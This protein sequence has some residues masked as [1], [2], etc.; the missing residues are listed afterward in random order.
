MLSDVDE[1][2]DIKSEK[3]D[4]KAFEYASRNF[5]VY[6]ER[7]KEVMRDVVGYGY[8]LYTRA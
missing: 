4:V 6:G 7:M 2:P 3:L 1:I 8:D 5:N